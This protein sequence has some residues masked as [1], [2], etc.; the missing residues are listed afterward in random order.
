MAWAQLAR[1]SFLLQDPRCTL[2][3]ITAL[4]PFSDS[5]AVSHRFRRYAELTPTELRRRGGLDL[6]LARFER[7]LRDRDG[8]GTRRSAPRDESAHDLT[9][10]DMVP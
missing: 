9:H 5:F 6:L 7:M 10:A 3:H 2:A 1:A 8:S 4:L